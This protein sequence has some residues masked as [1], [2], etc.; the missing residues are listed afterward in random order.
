[1]AEAQKYYTFAQSKYREALA[2]KS[3]AIRATSERGLHDVI[4]G[5]ERATKKAAR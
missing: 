1:M 5:L 4:R 2:T 3:V